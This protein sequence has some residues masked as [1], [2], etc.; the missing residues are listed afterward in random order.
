MTC[1]TCVHYLPSQEAGQR[2]WLEGY[3][4]CKAGTTREERCSF[5]AAS[6]ACWLTP[7]RYKAGK[8]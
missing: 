3:G 4:Y 6:S 2:A 5:F 8:P 7:P 1:E